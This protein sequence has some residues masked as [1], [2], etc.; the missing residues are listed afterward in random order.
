[1]QSW[2]EAEDKFLDAPGEVDK[3]VVYKVS[4]KQIK[5]EDFLG[6]VSAS[7]LKLLSQLN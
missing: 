7:I 1:M 4:R 3:F 2:T 5:P 6:F